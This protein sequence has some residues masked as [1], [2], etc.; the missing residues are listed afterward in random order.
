[1]RAVGNRTV[2]TLY[3][4]R[5]RTEG[6]PVHRAVWDGKVPLDLLLHRQHPLNGTGGGMRRAGRP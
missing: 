3:A 5:R 1:M 6:S 4:D 2:E